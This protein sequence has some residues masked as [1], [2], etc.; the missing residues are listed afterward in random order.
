MIL[1]NYLLNQSALDNL[2]ALDH[3]DP[4]SPAESYSYTAIDIETTGL[5][6]KTSRI[7][8]I[9]ALKIE[10]GRI[11]LGKRLTLLV[12]PGKKISIES[13]KIH[14]IVPSSIKDAPGGKTAID[15]F[16]A[17]IGQDILIGHKVGFDLNFLNKLMTARHGFPLQNLVIDT[18]SLSNNILGSPH[19]LPALVRRSKLLGRGAVLQH[20]SKKKWSL[21]E[22]AEQ[23]GFA[24]YQRHTAIGDALTSA[25]IFQ[26]I[27]SMMEASGKASL[28]HLIKAGA[29]NA[30]FK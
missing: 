30:S 4:K 8:S 22:A 25:L 3:I 21:D 17:F 2:K 20:I 18:F 11:R 7:V 5:D 12:N 15:Q 13:I 10:K 9:G 16:L 14:G 19:N 26:H 29:V 24:P 1:E 28:A 27:L 6:L 23:L